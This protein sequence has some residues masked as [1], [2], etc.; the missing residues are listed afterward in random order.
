MNQNELKNLINEIHGHA[1]LPQGR[2]G[3]WI[4]GSRARNKSHRLK[5]KHNLTK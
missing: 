1:I 2:Y 4:G 3:V 5:N